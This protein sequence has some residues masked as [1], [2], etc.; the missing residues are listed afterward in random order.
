M[1]I[2]AFV[3]S[4]GFFT[5]LI[6]FYFNTEIRHEVLRQV[7]RSLLRHD[8]VR[9]SSVGDTL[10]TR[11]SVFRMSMNRRRQSSIPNRQDKRRT[12]VPSA[13]PPV[14]PETRLIRC[15]KFLSSLCPCLIK[16]HSKPV[17]QQRARGQHPIE[18]IH[19]NN[20][21]S[22]PILTP[23]DDLG[24][25]A[26]TLAS[27]TDSTKGAFDND[28]LTCETLVVKNDHENNDDDDVLSDE[29]DVT[30]HH[31]SFNGEQISLMSSQTPL[32]TRN[33]PRENLRTR[34]KSDG[35]T[36]KELAYDYF[37]EQKSL[38]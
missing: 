36:L 15:R 16:K 5:S 31:T 8:T 29:N 25:M 11:L 24:G 27:P 9:R 7:Q 12:T 21:T 2:F 17:T 33:L 38:R 22:P 10:S 18:P 1:K 32:L 3:C 23:M 34:S 20:E 14:V 13:A 30:F 4:K 26:S 19:A 28:G 6:Y 35:H 37:E